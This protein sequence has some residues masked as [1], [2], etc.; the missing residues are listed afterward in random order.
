MINNRFT[1]WEVSDDA[2]K[3]HGPF[4]NLELKENKFPVKV[5]A[6]KYQ[7]FFYGDKL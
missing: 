1:S 7:L 5:I 3:P 4:R 6:K 2:Q